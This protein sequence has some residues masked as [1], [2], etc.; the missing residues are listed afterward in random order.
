MSSEDRQ[1]IDRIGFVERLID[2]CGSSKV[3]EVQDL[4]G[5]QYQTARNYLAG[6][7]P[8]AEMLLRISERT[9]CS[10]DWLLT[11]RGK[12]FVDGALEVDTLVFPRQIETFVR[13]LC[14]EVFNEEIGKHELV[15]YPKA[16]ELK[17]GNLM[18]EKILD[19]SR[20]LTGRES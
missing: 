11:G 20:A 18:K 12:K 7:V 15:D 8:T 17:S 4:L 6:R 19:R 9:S 10:I 13:R 5:V 14:V 2:A 1:V 16:F 3:T